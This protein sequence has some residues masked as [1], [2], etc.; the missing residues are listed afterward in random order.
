MN[1]HG[2][3]WGEKKK[4]NQKCSILCDSIYETLKNYI[5]LE[6]KN[7]FVIAKV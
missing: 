5:I 4:L 1:C 7:R 3:L 6:M 2:I